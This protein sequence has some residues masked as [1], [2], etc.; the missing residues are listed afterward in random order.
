MSRIKREMGRFLIV[1]GA[2]FGTDLAIYWALIRFLDR[3]VAKAASFV[4]ASILAYVLNKYWTF[5][6]MK[7]SY[8]QMVKFAILY[9]ST[10]GANVAV[11]KTSLIL[12]PDLV[13]FAFL[14][15]SGTSTILNFTG[16]KWWVFNDDLN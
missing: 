2:A 16:Q 3:S 1:G 8:S 15:A 6:K 10:L 9:I 11:N 5:S 13:L 12:F 7:K 14:A 4:L